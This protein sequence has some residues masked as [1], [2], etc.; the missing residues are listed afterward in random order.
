MMRPKERKGRKGDPLARGGQY[1][2]LMRKMFATR[3]K[4]RKK[5]PVGA[6]IN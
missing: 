2:R 4:R 1:L 3:A 6:L 5:R